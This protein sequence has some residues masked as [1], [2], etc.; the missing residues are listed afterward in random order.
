M[1]TQTKHRRREATHCMLT[2]GDSDL[3]SSLCKQYIVFKNKLQSIL[4]LYSL[5][6]CMKDVC[7]S[8]QGSSHQSVVSVFVSLA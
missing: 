2:G 1:E 6:D 8:R 3:S 5:N 7:L 4:I